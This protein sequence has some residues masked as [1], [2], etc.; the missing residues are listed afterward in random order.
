MS[1]LPPEPD[2][3]LKPTVDKHRQ[4]FGNEPIRKW[5]VARREFFILKMLNAGINNEKTNKDF[6]YFKGRIAEC[7]DAIEMFD[8]ERV[9]I[10]IPS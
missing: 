2:E 5:F 3:E 10:V 6:R 7:D 8:K 9:N 4:S 1:I